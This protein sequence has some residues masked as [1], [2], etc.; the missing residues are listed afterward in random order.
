MR[1]LPGRS[2]YRNG[3][4]KFRIPFHSDGTVKG[5]ISII[6]FSTS[7]S[8]L[9]AQRCS[10]HHSWPEAQPECQRRKC[11]SECACWQLKAYFLILDPC[12]VSWSLMRYVPT[13]ALAVVFSRSQLSLD[14]CIL[15][16][17]TPICKIRQ[18]TS[19]SRIVSLS[20]GINK[21]SLQHFTLLQF[22]SATILS[23]IR[24]P[25]RGFARS[26]ILTPSPMKKASSDM[27]NRVVRNLP[28]LL[29]TQNLHIQKRTMF[30]YAGF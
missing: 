15:H 5:Q 30:K 21:T 26:M 19:R 16:H 23:K 6:R 24:K 17:E 2:V 11:L 12:T 18:F 27:W 9:H 20:Q 7:E 13:L 8:L 1:A 29:T 10:E 25:L 28:A 3:E 4:S 14:T 22:A